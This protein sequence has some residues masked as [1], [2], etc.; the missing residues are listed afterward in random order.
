MLSVKIQFLLILMVQS[1]FVSNK[2]PYSDKSFMSRVVAVCAD[3]AWLMI[4]RKFGS[5][6]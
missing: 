5:L 2:R 3:R 1:F 6:G 4:W